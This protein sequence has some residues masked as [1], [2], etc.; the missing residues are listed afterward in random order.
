LFRI[1]DHIISL[2]AVFLA[3]GLGILIG[4]GLSDDMLVTQQRLLIDQMSKDV[5]ALREDRLTL[6]AQLQTVTR[7][8]YLWEKYQEALYPGVVAGALAEKRV[9]FVCHGAE[10]PPGVLHMLEDADAILSGVITIEGRQTLGADPAELGDALAAL[11]AGDV[12]TAEMGALLQPYFDE[13][14]IRLEQYGNLKPDAVIFV[15]GGRENADRRLVEETVVALGHDRFSLIGME[16]SDVNDS[17]LE[18]LKAAGV[19]T[20]DN[21]DTVFGQFS[22]ISVLRGSAGSYGIKAAADEFIANF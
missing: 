21:V 9:T 8:L 16:W 1:R 18:G 13:D 11:A 20:I 22:L 19:S 3:L 2:V 15:L 5:R 7:D 17:L 14:V 10:I 6:E 12:L 4:T